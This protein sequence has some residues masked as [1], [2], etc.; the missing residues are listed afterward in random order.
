MIFIFRRFSLGNF[1]YNRETR[2]D[3]QINIKVKII[4]LIIIYA[5][6]TYFSAIVKKRHFNDI[7]NESV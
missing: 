6:Q 1:F 3:R 5:I 2:K 4:Q 7:F